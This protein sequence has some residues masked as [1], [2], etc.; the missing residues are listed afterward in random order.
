[1]SFLQ[2]IKSEISKS[3]KEKSGSINNNKISSNSHDSG[4]SQNVDNAAN[5]LD[6]SFLYSIQRPRFENV[7]AIG[8]IPSLYYIPEIISTEDQIKIVSHIHSEG[9]KPNI[10]TVLKTRK[11]QL[12]DSSDPKSSISF[13][14][15]LQQLCDMLIDMNVFSQDTAIPNHVLINHYEKGQGILH[16]TDGPSYYPKVAILSLESS[17]IMTFRKRLESSLIGSEYNGDLFSV[18][19]KPRSLLVFTDDV[20]TQYMHGIINNAD[21]D[22]VGVKH[23][24]VENNNNLYDNIENSPHFLCL[25]QKDANIEVGDII[26]RSNRIS[27]TFRHKLN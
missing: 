25:N 1:M 8:S 23:D 15:W 21:Y 18:V 10:W 22:I 26:E 5:H 9:L 4:A 7:N 27:L 11:L 13:P 16:H 3:K 2:K 19:L 24:I 20:Y 14:V 6:T 12:W 17:C